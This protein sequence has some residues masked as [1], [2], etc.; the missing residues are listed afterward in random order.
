MRVLVDECLPRRLK[1]ALHDHECST[2][3]EAGFAGKKN[4]ELLALA[5][6]R[7]DVLITIDAGMPYQ[8]NLAGHEISLVLLSAKSNRLADLE[9]LVPEILRALECLQPQQ[10]V[11]IRA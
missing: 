1:A 8:Q 9:P 11:R 3:P 10:V 7:Y 6:G 5:A 2:V 4:G